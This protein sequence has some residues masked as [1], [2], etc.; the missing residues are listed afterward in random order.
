MPQDSS[1]DA[2]GKK[3]RLGGGAEDDTRTGAAVRVISLQSAFSCASVIQ[4]CASRRI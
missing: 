3:R 2:A 4:S 1:V